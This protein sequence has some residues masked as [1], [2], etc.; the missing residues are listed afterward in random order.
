MEATRITQHTLTLDDSEMADLR[1]LVHLACT[2]PDGENAQTITDPRVGASV[3]DLIM[4]PGLRQ[5]ASRFL[6]ETWYH[7]AAT[8]PPA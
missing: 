7:E 3:S 2:I 1:R 8:S 5:F 6:R 4:Q